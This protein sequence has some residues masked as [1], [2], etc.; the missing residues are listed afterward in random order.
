[1]ENL[2]DVRRDMVNVIQESTQAM[3]AVDLIRCYVEA[4]NECNWGI[5]LHTS[6]I[7][8]LAKKRYCLIY[9]YN[10]GE[11]FYKNRLNREFD[12]YEDINQLRKI[13]SYCFLG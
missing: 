12:T 1:M 9:P 3:I 10:M 6:V 2:P 4:F 13:M 7:S 8:K 5:L 11:Q